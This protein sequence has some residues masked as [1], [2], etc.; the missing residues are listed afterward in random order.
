VALFGD[1]L[2]IDSLEASLQSSRD[3][4]LV[5]IP[6]SVGNAVERLKTLCPDLVIIDSLGPSLQYVVPFLRDRPDIP[7]L[8]L[9][10][11]CSQVIVLS[12]QHHPAPTASAL[13]HLIELQ[14]AAPE[15]AWAA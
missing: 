4:G 15:I 11:D 10:V 12:G 13:A 9:D 2:F 3:L 8:C 6:A 7:L 1:S 5:R 14:T